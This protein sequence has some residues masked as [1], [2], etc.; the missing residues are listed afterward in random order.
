MFNG[1]YI[2]NPGPYSIAMLVYRSVFVHFE[3]AVNFQG[4][5][6]GYNFLDLRLSSNLQKLSLQLMVYFFGGGP[7]GLG[8]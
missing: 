4:K 5:L 2:F 6:D 7:G 3:G 8:F 1:K